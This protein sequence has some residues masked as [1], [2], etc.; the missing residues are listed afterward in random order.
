MDGLLVWDQFS[1]PGSGVGDIADGMDWAYDAC[2]FSSNLYVVGYDN[3]PGGTDF[4]DYQ[5]RVEKRDLVDGSLVWSRVFNPTD[6]AEFARG[7][8]VDMSGVYIVGVDFTVGDVESQ[9]RVE[10]RSH[11][12]GSLLW[13]QHSNQVF[14]YLESAMGVAV[15]SSGVYV[16]GYTSTGEPKPVWRIEKRNPSDGVLI[17][18]QSV[19]PIVCTGIPVR[20]ALDDTGLY[21]VGYDDSQGDHQWRI[22][23]RNL[24]DGSLITEVYLEVMTSYSTAGQSSWVQK[25]T[26][27]SVQ[28]GQTAVD[29]GNGTRRAFNGWY[30]D[31]S[32]LSAQPNF[33]I[34]VNAPTT[35]VASWQTEYL[36]QVNT[37]TGTA[38]GGGWLVSGSTATV[39]ITPTSLDR[40]FMTKLVFEGW[41]AGGNL[42]STSAQYAFTVTGPESLTA[43]W[44]T[45]QNLTIILGLGGGGLALGAVIVLFLVRK[46]KSSAPAQ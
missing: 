5:W 29:H 6:H 8:A 40:D 16:V 46:P 23:K 2:I 36:I 42:V 38:S 28:L 10:K 11:T 17:W 7:V 13:V 31:G 4:S 25:G 30:S 24:E 34:A 37:E 15:D 27:V 19:D 35:L 41:L 9:W 12:D 39:T 45:E 26:T 22:E 18:S 44:R 33:T 21:V 1:D 14:F 20:V 3:S 32:L 43:S